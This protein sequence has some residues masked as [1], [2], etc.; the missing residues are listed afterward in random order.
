MELSLTS[1]DKFILESFLYQFNDQ[2]MG[3]INQVEA[4]Y[5]LKILRR[6]EETECSYRDQFGNF[7]YSFTS[8]EYRKPYLDHFV[9][10]LLEKYDLTKKSLWGNHPFAFILS[11]DVDLVNKNHFKQDFR[12]SIKYLVK[13]QGLEKS[14]FVLHFALIFRN[15]LLR[16]RKKGDTI[17]GYEKWIDLEK[18][19]NYNSTYFIFI[20]PKLKDLHKYDCDFLLSDVFRFRNK[21]I[22]GFQY[23]KEIVKSGSEIGL[24]GSYHAAKNS[25]L[26][27]NQLSFLQN[28]V[29]FSIKSYRNHYLQFDSKITPL[30][31]SKTEIEVD[32]SLG[33]NRDIGFRAGTSFPFYFFNENMVRPILEV[34]QLIMDSALFLSNSLELDTSL[35]K[36]K[37]IEIMDRVE[38][39]GGIFTVNYHPDKV[40]KQNYFDTYEFILDEL[41]KRNAKCLNHSMLLSRMERN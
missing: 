36:S 26:I 6:E 1:Y 2:L 34:S 40:R 13:S 32:S 29:D 9:Y 4:D 39:V 33:F 35:A 27:K 3:K 20:K 24:H 12:A 15:I 8:Q 19:Y 30:E 10:S 41:K 21:K 17:W 16:I 31:L 7:E 18:L 28:T 38:E 22:S 11:H 23:I 37:I 5:I 25:F 14:K